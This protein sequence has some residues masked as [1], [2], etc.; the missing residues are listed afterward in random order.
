MVHSVGAYGWLRRELEANELQKC[1]K[2]ND[3]S[4]GRRKGV[5]GK[6]FRSP[7]GICWCFCPESLNIP[8]SG[9]EREKR[10]KCECVCV[11]NDKSE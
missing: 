7:A 1:S 8:T 6:L 11:I 5:A 2:Y 3:L 4:F 10:E 9:I